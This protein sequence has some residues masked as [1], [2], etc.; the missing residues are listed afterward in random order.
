MTSIFNLS[1]DIPKYVKN[2][3]NP[4]PLTR[5]EIVKTLIKEGAINLDNVFTIYHNHVPTHSVK[6]AYLVK[7]TLIFYSSMD[8]KAIGQI[9]SK[10]AN[11]LYYVLTIVEEEQNDYLA[12]IIEDQTS[13]DGFSKELDEIIEELKR[14]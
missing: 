7:T 5:K 12:T 14:E 13:Q 9:L 6:I 8:K 3:T 10:F 1:Y 11:N 4:N 2:A